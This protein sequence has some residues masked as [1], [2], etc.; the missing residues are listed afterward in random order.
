MAV[1]LKTE[2]L[3]FYRDVMRLS[4]VFN[5]VFDPQ[6]RDMGFLLRQSARNEFRQHMFE[7]DANTIASLLINGQAAYMEI[8]NRLTD[9]QREL[10]QRF[11][12][13][14]FFPRDPFRS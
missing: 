13:N 11:N 4:R 1:S 9:P 2:V 10:A 12:A 3:S 7:R 14:R 6:Y 5:G 8:Q